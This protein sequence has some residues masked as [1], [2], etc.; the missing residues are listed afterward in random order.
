MEAKS[1]FGVQVMIHTLLC[2]LPPSPPY[3]RCIQLPLKAVHRPNLKVVP[4][5]AQGSSSV[6]GKA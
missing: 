5:G 1:Q 6:T 4:A 3:L 2:P